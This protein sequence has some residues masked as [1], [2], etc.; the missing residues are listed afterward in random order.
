MMWSRWASFGQVPLYWLIHRYRIP[1][2]GPTS[3]PV[4]DKSDSLYIHIYQIIIWLKEPHHV[5]LVVKLT[6]FY[7]MIKLT[8]KFIILLHCKRIL[9]ILGFKI[10]VAYYLFCD[11]NFHLDKDVNT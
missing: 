8:R 9:K 6:S 5:T 1:L 7:F 11:T 3:Y 2:D 10:S 4:L